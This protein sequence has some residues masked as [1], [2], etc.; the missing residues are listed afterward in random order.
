MPII[1]RTRTRVANSRR[2]N[3]AIRYLDLVDAVK[4]RN[5]TISDS[6]RTAAKTKIDNRIQEKQAEFQRRR[7]ATTRRRLRSRPVLFK[8]AKQTVSTLVAEHSPTNAKRILETWA[9][10]SKN[11]SP[12]RLVEGQIPGVRNRKRNLNSWPTR[13]I[14]ETEQEQ[15]LRAVSQ[16]VRKAFGIAQRGRLSAFKISVRTLFK[17]FQTRRFFVVHQ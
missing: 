16:S 14:V 17:K 9:T 12:L 2:L 6:A 15:S 5:V 13:F 10:R 11:T 8:Q 1:N 4:F 3:S 7:S